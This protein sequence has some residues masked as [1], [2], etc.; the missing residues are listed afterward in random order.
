VAS[1][2][3]ILLFYAEVADTLRGGVFE[4]MLGEGGRRRRQLSELW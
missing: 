2:L 3:A 4:W 1:H